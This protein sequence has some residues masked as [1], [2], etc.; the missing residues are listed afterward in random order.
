MVAT[1]PDDVPSAAPIKNELETCPKCGG[2][3]LIPEIS[4]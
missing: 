4:N 3:G 2:S 1:A